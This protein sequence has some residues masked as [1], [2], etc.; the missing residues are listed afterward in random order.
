M[1][2]EKTM[3]ATVSIGGVIHPSLQRTLS[4]V[5]KSVGFLVSKYKA[6][7]AITLTGAVAGVAS[8]GAITAK[9]VGQAIE[10]QK[11]CPMW[12]PFW[13]AMFTRG[14][15]S[16]RRMFWIFPTRHPFYERPDQRTL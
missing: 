4:R 15:E 8:L 5:H 13:T 11:R 3:K 1:A 16:C 14:L 2:R 7:G 9:S 10:L 6:L 12:Q